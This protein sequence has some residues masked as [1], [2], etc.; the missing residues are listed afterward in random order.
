MIRHE[1]TP[2]LKWA[3]LAKIR[4]KWVYFIFGISLKTEYILKKRNLKPGFLE[5]RDY[6][7][8]KDKIR[9]YIGLK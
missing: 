6:W 1:T 8:I 4:L 2:F 7:A 5:M 3:P 9:P